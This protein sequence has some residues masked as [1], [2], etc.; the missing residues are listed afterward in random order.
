MRGFQTYEDLA[1][2]LPGSLHTGSL[3]LEQVG[4]GLPSK[5]GRTGRL[6]AQRSIWPGTA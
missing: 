3:A 1:G 4:V 6:E 5:S 2:A